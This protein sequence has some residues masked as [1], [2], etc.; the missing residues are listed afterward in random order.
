[1]FSGRLAGC[2][3]GKVVACGFQ[4]E[5]VRWGLELGA[6]M[7]KVVPRVIERV[8]QEAERARKPSVSSP[9]M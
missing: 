6:E 8:L 3:P 1:L 4:P 2:P 9:T 5:R 7:A